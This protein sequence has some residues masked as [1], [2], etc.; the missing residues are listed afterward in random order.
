MLRFNWRRAPDTYTADE[1]RERL[2]D[3]DADDPRTRAVR[4]AASETGRWMSRLDR[5]RAAD[6][7]E[8]MARRL[9]TIVFWYARGRTLDEIGA[10]LT[11]FGCDWAAERAMRAAAACIAACLNA[12]RCGGSQLGSP[13]SC[14][15]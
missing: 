2:R 14:A 1:V 6:L 4:A 3:L 7:G 11:V 12:C 15:S 13:C 8:R 5:R 9:P 10:D